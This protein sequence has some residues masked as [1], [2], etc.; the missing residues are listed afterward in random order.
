MHADDQAVPRGGATATAKTLVVSSCACGAAG[1]ACPSPYPH[2]RT[3]AHAERLCHCKLPWCYS[4]SACLPVFAPTLSWWPPL[5]GH[6]THIRQPAC[7]PAAAYIQHL[8]TPT[9]TPTP[10]PPAS[11][12]PPASFSYCECFA[13]GRYCAHCNCINCFNNKENEAVRQAAVEAILDR[14]PNAFRPKIQVITGKAVAAIL[15]VAAVAAVVAVAAVA[16]CA[17]HPSPSLPPC[18]ICAQ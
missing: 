12:P 17:R 3:A 6:H 4:L 11:V 10:T 18:Q 5:A 15:A 16:L 13:S 8:F 14:N 1:A 7:L 9:P 2:T